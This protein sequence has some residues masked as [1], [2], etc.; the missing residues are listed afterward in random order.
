M[1]SSKKIFWSLAFTAILAGGSASVL[2]QQQTPP[3]V[4]DE[5]EPAPQS[6]L[7]EVIVSARRRDENLQDVPISI[8]AVTGYEMEVRGIERVEDVIASVPNVM[9]SGGPSTAFSQ[10]AIRGIPRAGFF[11]DDVWQQSTLSVSQRS[12]MELERVEILR[13]PQGTLYGRD[14]T[15]GAIRLYTKLPAQEFGVRATAIVGS[16][17]RLD[18]TLNADL[19]VSDTL[20]TKISVIS[21]ERDGY[22]DSI[23]I[24]R[25]YGGMD[26]QQIRGDVLWTPNDQFQARFSA[27]DMSFEG[28]QA[29]VTLH[30]FD[31]C[32]PGIQ[33]GC[34]EPGSL[35]WVPN[36][37]YYELVGH[38]YNSHSQ[39]MDYPGGLV[40]DL[41]NRSVYTGPGIKIDVQ[42]YN[43]NL[44]YDFSDEI[45]LRSITHYH[46]QK[47]W[48]YND[49]SA[50]DTQYFSQGGPSKREGW[51]QEFQLTGD[52][53]RIH[54]V[55]GF[56]DWH[57]Q[58]FEHFMRWALWE[59][60][61]GELDFADVTSSPECSSFFTPAF[62]GGPPQG[63]LSGLIP[64][65][66]VPPSQDSM[67]SSTERGWAFFG[68]MTY[69]ITDQWSA[70]F[71]AR[72]HYQTHTDWTQLFSPETARRSPIPGTIP[73]GDPFASAGKVDPRI[74]DFN[75]DTYKLSTTYN[76]T[77]D[78]M[79]Y[80]SYSQG[81]NAGGISRV[82]I[83]DLENNAINYDFPY[84]PEEIDNYEIGLR[85]DWLDETL[86]A[87]VTLFYT[88]WDQIQLSGTVRNPFTGV[89]LP[90]FVITN[91]ASATAK[92]VEVE[93]TY[94]PNENWQFD[95]D[96][97][98]LNTGY[99]EIAPGSELSLDDNFG[100]APEFQYTVGGQYSGGFSNGMNYTIRLDWNWT[101]G[102]NRNYV[103]GDW[104]TTYTGEKW[105]VSSFGLLNARFVLY[106]TDRWEVAFFGTNLTDSRY[107]DAGFMSPLL[108]VD[109]GTVG[110]PREW[111][112]SVRFAF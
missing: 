75:F 88:T 95:L 14:T 21:A 62:P 31:P 69:D 56:Y 99:D 66:Q 2:A 65:I 46:H 109:D 45:S 50:S 81:Y 100:M 91:A 67:T 74:S 92:G 77:D 96:F 6:G 35:F 39:V 17:D 57:E 59:F 32:G 42:N 15:G 78:L 54:W 82:Q 94:V 107:S 106:P 89:V 25:S 47:T 3:V 24:D 28:T 97:A 19:P 87:N 61:T 5:V 34:Q 40:G 22:V 60:A 86:R 29:N 58:E 52:H 71:G 18:L 8:V 83:F 108:Q 53:D 48:D 9:V 101:A 20:L 16:Y 84:D 43:L 11:V 112:A 90:T 36:S 37:Q 27:E 13:G 98:S 104:S 12:V 93:L 38:E 85:S 30:M 1:H 41:E 49:F 26:D 70:T 68:E 72:Y 51:T 7:E 79:V 63:A 102:Y 4:E 10:F 110:R 33:P 44:T 73:A 105:E 80:G 103:P 111:G 23:I 55:A 64:C 76:F